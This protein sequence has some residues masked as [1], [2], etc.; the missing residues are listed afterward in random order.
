MTQAAQRVDV[1]KLVHGAVD[2]GACCLGLFVIKP[3]SSAQSHS[4]SPTG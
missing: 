4:P 2:D 1:E 3:A